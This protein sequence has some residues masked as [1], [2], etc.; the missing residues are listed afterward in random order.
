MYYEEKLID[1]ILHYRYSPKEDFKP[2]SIGKLS[3]MVVDLKD[4]LFNLQAELERAYYHLDSRK[5]ITNN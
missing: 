4:K 5:S 1:G 3:Q 2:M